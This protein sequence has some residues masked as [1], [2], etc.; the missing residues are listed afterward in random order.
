MITSIHQPSFFPW[1]GLLDK[2]A[3]SEQFIFLDD[4]PANKA[5][6][7]Y[8]NIFYCNGEEKMLTLPVDYEINKKLCNLKFKNNT[9]KSDH[10]NKLTNYYRKAPFFNVIFP[11]IANLYEYKSEFAVDFI[12]HTMQY[13]FD[14]FKI[15]VIMQKSSEIKYEGNKGWLVLDLCKKT[16]TTSYLSGKGAENYMEQDILSAFSAA[17]IELKWHSF[18]HPIYQQHVKYPFVTGLSFLDCLFFLG[19]EKANEMFWSNVNKG[20]NENNK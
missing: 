16:K 1:L 19:I 10:L 14:I 4:V 7:Q 20:R 15:N 11:A 6:Y 18:S 12:I 3:K 13:A 17:G 5:S 9:W 8:R 2:I